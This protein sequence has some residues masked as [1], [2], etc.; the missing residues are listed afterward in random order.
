[1]SPVARDDRATSISDWLGSWV[2][3]FR[4]ATVFSFAT[5]R[6]TDGSLNNDASA[7]LVTEAISS[8]LVAAEISRL[9]RSRAAN[10]LVK[11]V[12]SSALRCEVKETVLTVRPTTNSR[13]IAQIFA[14]SS[15]I[16]L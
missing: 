16:R 13:H 6:V 15:I 1:M 8:R 9:Y 7:R 2:P 5:I 4:I 3:V 12:A 10:C 14:G 11:R